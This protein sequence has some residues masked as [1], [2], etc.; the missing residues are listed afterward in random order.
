[1]FNFVIG[2]FLVYLGGVMSVLS[3]ADPNIKRFPKI[4][5]LISAQVVALLGVS[6]TVQSI[7]G[8]C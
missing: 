6:L 7:A 1:M 5:L 3:L 4:I 2:F 8:M